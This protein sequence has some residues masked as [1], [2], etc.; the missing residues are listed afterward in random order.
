MRKRSLFSSVL[1]I[2][3]VALLVVGGYVFFKD[4]DGPVVDVTPNTGKVSPAS[5]LKVRMQDPS[6][7]R[8]ISVGVRKNNV[9]N[10]IYSK[11]FDKYIPER[12]VEVPMKDANLREGA[13]ELEIRATDGSLAGFGQGNTRTIQLPMRLDTLPPRISVKTLPPNVRRGGTAV[14]RY[15]IDEEVSSSGVLVAGYFVPGYLQKDGSYICFF[16]FPYTMTARDYKNSVEITAT[17]LAGNITKSHLTVMTFERTFK[18]DSIEVTDN[19]L[20]AVESKLRDL[21][22]DATNPL[23]CYLYINNQ[24]RTANVQALREI[25]RDSASAM[26]WSGVFER[27]PR[28]APRAGFGDHR[29]FSY[30]GKPVGESYHLGFDLASVRNAEVPAANSGRVVFCGNLGIYGNL[31]VIDHGLGLMSLY[32]H[33]N[34]QLVK[35]GDVVQRGQIIAHTGS[36]GL[37]FGDHLHFGILVGGVEVTPLEWLDPKWIKDNITGRIDASM[38]QQ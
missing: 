26:L 12:E 10:V 28:S 8:S 37:A 4:L 34:D 6:G 15:T 24:V 31:I 27:L 20:L 3:V 25:G 38:T 22:P 9:L 14:V 5:V 1:G 2:L 18:S 33:L 21:A 7:I 16:P 17:D 29:F 13:F 30:Q 23:E 11:H 35:A 19:F 36:T 32:S